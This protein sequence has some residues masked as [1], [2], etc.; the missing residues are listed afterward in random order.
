MQVGKC[1]Q[2]QQL[3]VDR[4]EKYLYSTSL[5]FAVLKT[6]I[7]GGNGIYMACLYAHFPFLI[8]KLYR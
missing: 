1:K 7:N 8:K 6:N 5:H 2:R 3:D 4:K